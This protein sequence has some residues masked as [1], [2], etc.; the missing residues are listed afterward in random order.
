MKRFAF[1][2]WK[3]IKSW[4]NWFVP[5][6]QTKYVENLPEKLDQKAIYIIRDEGF[7]E[8]AT[9]LCPCRCGALLHMNLIPDERPLLVRLPNMIMERSVWNRL[10]GGRKAAKAIFS[11]SVDE[12]DGF[13]HDLAIY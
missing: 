11:L 12:F 1:L 4:R 8:H 7:V 10:F 3:I 9:L 5:P 6:Y 2:T 13:Q